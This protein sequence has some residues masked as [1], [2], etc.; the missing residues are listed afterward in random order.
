MTAL[1][2]DQVGARQ[3]ETGLDRGVLYL[4]NGSA[5]PWN[6]LTGLNEN[7]SREVKSF[8]TDG[9]KYLDHFILSDFSAN[10]TAYTYPDELDVLLGDAEYAPGVSLHD[11]RTKMFNLSYRTLIGND[12]ES[13]A[14]YKIHLL[15]NLTASPSDVQFASDGAQVAPVAFAWSLTST[16]SHFLGARPT[17]HITLN[18][19]KMDPAVLADIE[20][21]IYGTETT[22]PSLPTLVDFLNLIP[23]DVVEV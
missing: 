12:L 16:P 15:W 5:V 11:Q 9:I 22:N 4:P 14:G 7:R 17:S 3:Y 20:D 10:L 19:L 6:G 2:W 18:S 21:L 1:V 23:N 8:Y 13:D